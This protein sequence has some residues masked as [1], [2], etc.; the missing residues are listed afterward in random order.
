[1]KDCQNNNTLRLGAKI[2]TVGK[3][4]SNNATNAVLHNGKKEWLFCCKCKAPINFR[5]ELD[6]KTNAPKFIPC[7]GLNELFTRGT[8][9]CNKQTH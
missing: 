8:A 7:C 1:M 5:D 3:S 2:D 4:L 6:T 9:K